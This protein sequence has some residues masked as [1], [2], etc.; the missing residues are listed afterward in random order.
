MTSLWT[1]SKALHISL[2]KRL[3]DLKYVPYTI[4]YVI[5][6]LIQVD[7]FNELPKEKRPPS[8]IIWDGTPEELEEWIEEVVLEKHNNPTYGSIIIDLD[9]VE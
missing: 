4:S 1:I 9:E 6:K 8:S 3:E 2:D 5:R 7:T